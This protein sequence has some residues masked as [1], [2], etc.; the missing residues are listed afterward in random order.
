MK[1]NLKTVFSLLTFVFFISFNQSVFAAV[2]TCTNWTSIKVNNCT[3]AQWSATPRNPNCKVTSHIAGLQLNSTG[4]VTMR[5]ANTTTTTL[6]SDP[7][8]VYIGSRPYSASTSWTLSTGVGVKKVCVKFI[9]AT[10]SAVCGA[11]IQVVA[12]PSPTITLTPS[13]TVT[14]GGPT[15][16]PV[17]TATP[18]PSPTQP[19]LPCLCN[20]N[21]TCTMTRCTFSK[22]TNIT[23]ANPI[24]CKPLIAT[25]YVSNALPSSGQETDWCRRPQRTKGDANGDDVIDLVD[26][27]YTLTVAN[28]IAKIPPTINADFNG[29]GLV[30][31]TDKQIVI[32]S[33]NNSN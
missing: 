31:V 30:N 33:I 10:G 20:T 1:I 7:S 12:V 22:Y 23:Y 29:D 2:P 3:L 6:C 28:S 8:L 24:K 9:N 17:A 32:R 18:A 13:P 14:P 11:N 27:F 25:K 16:T 15:V 26:Y 4:A 21:N 19:S 5:F